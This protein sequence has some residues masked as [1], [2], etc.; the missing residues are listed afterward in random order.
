MVQ[1]RLG[2]VQA[3]WGYASWKRC[4]SWRWY[5]AATGERSFRK[6]LWKL[7]RSSLALNP[8]GPGPDDVVGAGSA[9]RTAQSRLSRLQRLGDPKRS[10]LLH[11]LRVL[12]SLERADPNG[13][14]M[15]AGLSSLSETRSDAS[16]VTASHFIAVTCYRVRTPDKF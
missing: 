10:K 5:F 14:R 8:Q 13:Y 16:R 15:S 3:N 9:A 12:D 11:T 7:R 1:R 2:D 6:G 4:W